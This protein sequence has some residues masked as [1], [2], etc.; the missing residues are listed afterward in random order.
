[1]VRVMFEKGKQKKF[2]KQALINL[3]CPSLRR[4]NQFGFDI[5]YQTLKSYFNENRTLPYEFFDNLCI[6][7]G[8]KPKVK[9]LEDN[10]GKVKGGKR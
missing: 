1:M 9:L 3:N 8:L 4:I 7:S 2:I 10:W 6:L 5:N